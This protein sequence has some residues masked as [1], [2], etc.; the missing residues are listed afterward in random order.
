M[1]NLGV[2]LLDKPS[3]PTSRQSAEQ[4]RR[5][6]GARKVGHGGTLD[7]KVT[8]V[9]PLLLDKARK[10]QAAFSRLD[11][12]YVGVMRLHADVEPGELASAVRRFTGKIVQVPPVRSKV[13]RQPRQ[14]RVFSFEI[15]GRDGRDV[16]FSVECEAGTYI[17]KLVHDLGEH[18]GVGAHMLRLRRTRSGP[19]PQHQCVTLEGLQEAVGRCDRGDEACLRGAVRNLED[20]IGLLLPRVWVDDGAV[21]SLCQG[22]PLAVPGICRLEETEAQRPV[23]VM[24][25]KGELVAIGESCMSSEQMLGASRGVAVTVDSVFMEPGVYPQWKPKA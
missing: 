6:L 3:G 20:V 22:F 23:A 16:E 1:V 14:R 4:A 15:L 19:F 17:R 10:A 18:L 12:A 21:N 5:L 13:K 7:A 11:K 8:G 2:V 24:T 9:L 25:L